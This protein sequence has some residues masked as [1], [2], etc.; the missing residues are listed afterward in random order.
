MP[1]NLSELDLDKISKEVNTSK[2]RVFRWFQRKKYRKEESLPKTYLESNL[3]L[4]V[5]SILEE[6]EDEDVL[7]LGNGQASQI[8]TQSTDFEPT[9]TNGQTPARKIYRF[10]PE[11]K[12]RL[13][14]FYNEDSTM[15]RGK[16]YMI[17]EVI[18]CPVEKVM[19]W[20]MNWRRQKMEKGQEKVI[21]EDVMA[22]PPPT[23]DGTTPTTTLATSFNQST[24][25]C[26]TPSVDKRRIFSDVHIE[27]MKQYYA[28]NPYNIESEKVHQFA[29]E[30]GC[31]PK[32]VYS[33]FYR[34]RD[35]DNPLHEK[36]QYGVGGKMRR[37]YYSQAQIDDLIECYKQNSSLRRGFELTHSC[38]KRGAYSPWSFRPTS[39]W[40]SIPRIRAQMKI[41]N[42]EK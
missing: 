12:E 3:N 15:P 27:I 31:T 24:S 11:Q 33:W 36:R 29:K 7:Q 22:L 8:Q 6:M 38:V 28:E 26:T 4:P 25:L 10:S 30:F 42:L 37:K 34:Q 9:S 21:F 39:S 35:K 40:S 20:W 16:K 1:Q 18:G 32:Q 17:A 19:T 13:I 41:S 14:Q 2:D 23:A 5:K